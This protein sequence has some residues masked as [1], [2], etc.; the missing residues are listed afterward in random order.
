MEA[1]PSASYSFTLRVEFPHRA[2]SLG[3]ILTTVGDAG[4]MVG[5]VDI[6]RMGQHRSTR[7]ITV[8]ARDSGHG[9]QVVKAVD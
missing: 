6:V 9:Q 4:A 5:A 2:G 7:D 8:N 3:K 1:I